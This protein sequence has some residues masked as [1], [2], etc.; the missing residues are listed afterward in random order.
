MYV[1]PFTGQAGLS[2]LPA[3]IKYI[4]K[5]AF[6]DCSAF[7]EINLPSTV[8]EIADSA[9]DGTALVEIN[10]PASVETIG[11]GVFTNCNSLIDINVDAKNR[12]FASV[13]GALYDIDLETLICCP[14]GKSGTFVVY[15]GVTEI[16]ADGFIGCENL[17]VVEIPSSV[18]TIAANAFNGCSDDIVIKADCNS[19]AI[20]FAVKRGI[21]NE[22]VHVGGDEWQVTLEPTCLD[23][24]AKEL[25]CSGCGFVHESVAIP[26]LDH[27]Y[28]D[29]VVTTKATCEADGVITFTCTRE[30]CDDSYTKPIPA[31]KHNFDNG[32]VISSATCEN[33]GTMRYSC[34]NSGCYEYYDE[35]IPALG[36][37]MDDGTI[38]TKA[39]CETDGE[40]VYKCLNSGCLK[41]ESEV[42]PAT[43]H[44]MDDGTVAL[45]AT[46]TEDGEK[47]YK[48]Q[49]ADCDHEESVVLPATGHDYEAKSTKATC[50]KDG[51]ITYTCKNCGD[52]YKE[53]FKGDHSLV[54]TK[55]EPTCDKEGEEGM[56][57][58]L[59]HQFVGETKVIAAKGHTFKNGKCVD[60][61]KSSGV[62]KPGTPKLVSVKN[63]IRG[64][65][66]KWKAAKNATVYKVYVLKSTGK[67]SCIATLDAEDGVSYV[68]T[69]AKSGTKYTYTVKALNGDVPGGYDKNGISITFIDDPEL[70]SIANAADGVKVTWGK[71]TGATKYAVY[72]RTAATDWK[73]IATVKGTSYVD[74]NVKSGTGYIYVVRA[75]DGSTLS[76]YD[77]NGINIVFVGAPKLSSATS[78]KSGIVL[79]WSK[80]A[81]ADGYIVYRKTS[82]GEY[83]RI[84]KVKGNAT[85]S[86][87]DKSA[88][89]GVKYTYVVKA[90]D[91]STKSYK[92]NAK[93]LKDKY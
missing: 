18:T 9:F 43:G 23:D 35:V 4:G 74:K 79:K 25:V 64:P 5:N 89:K 22:P 61:G 32:K 71:V 52:T 10:I 58:V 51:V 34:Q 55:T 49:N 84:A 65:I 37:N 54:S 47:V 86:Y 14:A 90:Y 67:W 56:F 11:A 29:G 46:C 59:C 17:E 75:S 93:T 53:T 72:R 1:S 30:G 40:K 50:I 44:K 15:N 6:K 57:C 36:H 68:H 80:V 70:K 7:N 12:F 33:D 20:A 16:G 60:C 66:L 2:A 82:G 48:C 26:A 91:G 78:T 24:G 41:K 92:S 19:A 85:V 88:K 38:K 31:T 45:A 13:D 87:K 42:I 28:D 8:E 73:K 83:E 27:D 69:K 63:T 39:T 76:S 3:G 81:K 21:D 62:A 77:G